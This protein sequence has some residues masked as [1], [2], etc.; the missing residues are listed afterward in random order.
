ML[1][2]IISGGQRG[3]DQAAL[4]AAIK[5]NFPHGGWIQKGRRIKGGV[6]PDK[7]ELKEMPIP[8][9]KDRIERNVMDSDGTA[10]FS[11]GMLTGGADYS[12][13]MVQKHQRP[14]LHVDLKKTP[15]TL[16]SSKLN[17]WAME[18]LI[19]V[20]NI[21]GSRVSEDSAIYGDTMH[22]VENTIL[23]SLMNAESGETLSDYN[24]KE[25]LDHLPILPETVDEAVDQALSGLTAKDQMKIARAELDDLLDDPE[26]NLPNGIGRYSD[27]W[28]GNTKLLVSCRTA[29]DEDVYGDDEVRAV[30]IRRIWTKLRQGGMLRVVQ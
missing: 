19:K 6:L 17:A 14:G 28:S 5:Y 27:R 9:Y 20:L 25:L 30:I 8:G 2:K 24:R 26:A 1:K 18:N 3:A 29:S 23:L 16:A 4:D 22:I 11:H 15:A 13:Q 7:Y 12:L 10:I 21:A